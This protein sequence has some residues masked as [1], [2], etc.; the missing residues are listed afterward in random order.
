M[1]NDYETAAVTV[2][3]SAHEVILGSKTEIP[4]D[5]DVD[6]FLDVMDDDE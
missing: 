4:R 6:P 1:K 5:S 3:G 2:I